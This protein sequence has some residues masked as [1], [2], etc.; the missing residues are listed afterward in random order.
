MLAADLLTVLLVAGIVVLIISTTIMAMN[1]APRAR[2]R[3]RR[4]GRQLSDTAAHTLALAEARAATH[5]AE[6]ATVGVAAGPRQ[7]S[8]A[9]AVA[10]GGVTGQ[11]IDIS[12]GLFQVRGA[13]REMTVEYAQAIAEHVAETDPQRVAEVI[14]QWIRA[15]ST[16]DPDLFR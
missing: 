5:R 9:G 13:S 4:S 2:R 16:I 12:D 7:G 8:A 1:F 3:R 14:S 15:D 11:V 10:G 6:L